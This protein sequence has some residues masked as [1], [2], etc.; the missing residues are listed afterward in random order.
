MSDAIPGSSNEPI[1]QIPKGSTFVPLNARKHLKQ[2][3]QLL[4][5]PSPL[6]FHLFRKSGA[7]QHGV[8]LQHIMLHGT[9]TSHCVWR[10][11]S[12]S[13]SVKLDN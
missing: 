5:L 11:V 4:H 13:F 9:W 10:Y 12:H 8:P 1:F 3:S 2:L 6:T 7:F